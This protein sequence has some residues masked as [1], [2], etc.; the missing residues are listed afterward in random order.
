MIKKSKIKLNRLEREELFIF[1]A[2]IFALERAIKQL[3]VNIKLKPKEV[4]SIRYENAI[5]FKDEKILK[6]INK[7]TLIVTNKR[8][9]LVNPKDPS[10]L[11][12]FLLSKIKRLRLEN[13]VLKFLYNNKVYALSIYDNKVLLNILTNIIN[14]KVKKVDNGN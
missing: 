2:R 14:K 8:A 6:L 3:D 1:E 11:N 13:Q 9:L 5:L 4:A 10:I 12:Q 7:G